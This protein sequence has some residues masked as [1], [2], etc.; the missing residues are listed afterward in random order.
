MDHLR[1]HQDHM[2]ICFCYIETNTYVIRRVRKPSLSGHLPNM[3]HWLGLKISFVTI[4]C[5]P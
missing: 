3:E 5:I 2:L 1:G 4:L